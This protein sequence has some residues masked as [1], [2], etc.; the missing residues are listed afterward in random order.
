MNEA[1]ISQLQQDLA[2]QK[3]T[4]QLLTSRLNELHFEVESKCEAFVLA[5]LI[6]IF[7]PHFVLLIC[8]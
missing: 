7:F 5:E 6:C 3:N 2:A 4:M 1:T 8:Q